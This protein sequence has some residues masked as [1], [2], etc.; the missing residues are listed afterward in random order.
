VQ[1]ATRQLNP[2]N[3]VNSSDGEPAAPQP[4]ADRKQPIVKTMPLGLAKVCW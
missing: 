1:T 2:A 4:S 3:Q